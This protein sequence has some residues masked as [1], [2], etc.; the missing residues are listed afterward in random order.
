MENIK[1]QLIVFIRQ[2]IGKFKKRIDSL[3]KIE[4]DLGIT[5]DEAIELIQSISKFNIDISEFDYK[6]YFHPEP[7]F[8]TTYGNIKPLTIHDIQPRLFQ[9]SWFKPLCRICNP[10]NLY[11]KMSRE[12]IVGQRSL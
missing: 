11:V 10:K 8:L 5:G 12:F 2:E 6:R 7:N 3:T 1:E 9:E 4:D